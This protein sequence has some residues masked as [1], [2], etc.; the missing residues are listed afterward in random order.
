MNNNA[1]KQFVLSS[2]DYLGIP[3]EINQ[4]V[5]QLHIPDGL[6]NVFDS[7][8]YELSFDKT[9]NPNQLYVTTESYFIQKLAKIISSRLSGYCSGSIRF[10]LQ[11]IKD[12]ISPMFPDCEVT[13]GEKETIFDSVLM[14]WWKTKVKTF[15]MEEQ[16]KGL[17]YH[18]QSGEVEEV[19][20]HAL[21][22]FDHLDTEYP[23]HLSD[24]IIEQAYHILIEK[25]K[26]ASTQ[27]IQKKKLEAQHHLQQEIIRISNY[28]DLLI[29]ENATAETSKQNQ[30]LSQ[31]RE[32]LRKEKE[33]LIEQQREKYKV[34]ENSIQIEVYLVMLVTKQIEKGTIH[35]QNHHGHVSIPVMGDEKV[36]IQCAIT[37]RPH[38][39]FTITSDGR[40]IAKDQAFVCSHC[41]QCMDKSKRMSCS[42]CHKNFCKTCGIQSTVSNQW[43]CAVHAVECPSCLHHAGV[44]EF[45]KCL[46]CNQYYCRSCFNGDRCVLC[47]QL[48]P[49]KEM[50]KEIEEVISRVNIKASSYEFSQFGSRMYVLGKS[51]FRKNYLVIYDCN[52]QC[53]IEIIRYNW[54]GKIEN[55]NKQSNTSDS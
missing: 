46:N 53:I 35:I 55:L 42:I 43:L 16:T 17:Q 14:I 7:E 37:Q 52:A 24:E 23:D 8:I 10:P 19:P 34:D 51:M 13:V 6:K 1:L 45:R 31:E 41:F 47:D 36:K 3:V 39:P 50:K 12:G 21:Q 38:G 54:L 25:A 48:A 26:Q 20:D 44:D 4:N 29:Q 33:L 27:F 28:Y 2:C 22:L 30:N 11:R 15:M 40:I 32:M 5:Y 49:I 9:D 18:F